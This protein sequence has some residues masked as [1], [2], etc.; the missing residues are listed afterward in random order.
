MSMPLAPVIERINADLDHAVQRLFALLRIPSIS[1]D[2]AYDSDVKRAAQMLVD[3]LAGIG[4]DAKLHETTGHPMVIATTPGP[5]R[6]TCRTCCTT[7]ITTFSRPTRWSSGTVRRLSR[8]WLTV[9]TAGAF[10]PAARWTTR[11]K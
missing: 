1:T 2:S 10:S 9:S 5:G 8:C 11:G 6:T 4:F 7:V 3:D